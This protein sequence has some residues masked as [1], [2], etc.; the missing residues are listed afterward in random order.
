MDFIKQMIMQS[1]IVAHDATNCPDTDYAT[2]RKLHRGF[3]ANMAELYHNGKSSGLISIERLKTILDNRLR[4][5]EETSQT[6]ES[7]EHPISKK[8]L[9]E[10]IFSL[11]KMQYQQILDIWDKYCFTVLVTNQENQSLKNA[12]Q[13]FEVGVDCWKEMYQAHNIDTMVRPS[14]RKRNSYAEVDQQLSFIDE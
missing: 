5:I 11:P 12:Q 3:E 2:T 7:I 4:G 10:Y 9:S 8:A 1:Y 13:T 6:R 14:F